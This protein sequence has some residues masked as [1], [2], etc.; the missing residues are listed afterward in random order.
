MSRT[1]RQITKTPARGGRGMVVSHNVQAAETGIEVL[2]AGG[3]A[4]DAAVAMS[5]VTAVRETPMNS[6]GGLGVLLVHSASSGQTTEINFYG[7]TPAGLPEDVFVPYLG[8]VD[9]PRSGFGWRPVEGDRHDRGPLSVAVP[10]VVAGLAAL[11]GLSAV[12]GMTSL[13]PGTATMP[14][15]E[16]L[17]PA[18]ELARA[19]YQPDE[20]DA[21]QFASHLDQIRAAPDMARVLMPD[22]RLPMPD[23]TYQTATEPIRQLELAETIARIAADGPTAMYVGEIPAAMATYIQAQGGVVTPA[24]FAAVRPELGEGLRTTYKGYEVVTSSG[25]TGGLTLLQMLNLAEQLDLQRLDRM[26]GQFQHVLIEVMRQ[27]WTDRFVYVGDPEGA[28]VPFD[29]LIDKRYAAQLAPTLPT[30]RAPELTRPGDPWAFSR[31]SRPLEQPVSADPGGSETT[32][33]AV[34][35]G[36]GN[37]VTLT[38]TLGLAFGSYVM[39]TPTGVLLPNIT[40]WMNPEPGTPNSVGPAKKQLGHAAPVLLL[41]D[42]RP[43]ATLGAPGGRRIVTAMFQAIVGIVD[44]DLDVQSA[45]AAPR[46]HAEGADPVAP[47]GPTA[48]LVQVDDRMPDDVVAD[49]VRRGH[50]VKLVHESDAQGHLAQPLGIQFVSDGLLGGVDVFRRSVGIGL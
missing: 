28:S 6:I 31:A 20:R 8:P 39:P 15:S 9:G 7:R 17:R 30:D 10:H 22:G 5:F 35:D 46:L 2:R 1:R 29:G 41:K 18:M 24:D 33:L 50:E 49:L 43:V 12:P 32:H 34:A 26:S 13:P 36:A 27:A 42:G 14:W 19:G 21:F 16:L 40:S 3:T 25:T 37:V 23:G 47:I 44:F 11:S 38:Q 45:L 4:V 48:R